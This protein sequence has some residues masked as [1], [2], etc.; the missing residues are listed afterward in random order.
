MNGLSRFSIAVL[1]LTLVVTA[2]GPAAAP[3]PSPT[4]GG[5]TIPASPGAIVFPTP[6][7]TSVKIAFSGTPSIGTLPQLMSRGLG[8]FEKYGVKAEFVHFSGAAQSAQ[9]LQAGQVDVGDGSAGPVISTLTTSSPSR[10]VF[11]TRHNLTDNLYTQKTVTTAAQLR[12]KAVAIS[13]FGSQSHAGALL[14]LK[15]LGLTDKEV[16]LTPVG[17]DTARLAALKAGGVAGSMQDSAIAAELAPLGFNILVELTKVTTTLGGVPR[18][19]LVIPQEFEQK[20]PNTVLALVAAYLEG[21]TEMRKQPDKAAQILATDAQIPLENAK[22]QVQT[23]LAA[24]WEPRDGKCDATVMEF[25]KQTLLPTN[26]AIAAVDP[27]KACSNTYL[28][29]L[30]T[31]GFQKKIGVPGY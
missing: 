15:S 4:T 20:Y 5:T 22:V 10:M 3:S 12:G 25:T 28:E 31:M 9:A 29:K 1:S 26:P 14:A 19:S 11:I 18:T 16:T 7:K 27:V 13:S 6:E 24:P 30:Q 8:L 2:C 23:E 17:N 21:M